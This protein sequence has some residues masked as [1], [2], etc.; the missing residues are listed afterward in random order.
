MAQ[1]GA[2]PPFLGTICY[3]A[4]DFALEVLFTR[5]A[6]S[7]FLRLS[8]PFPAIVEISIAHVCSVPGSVWGGSALREKVKKRNFYNL[9]CVLIALCGV[10]LRVSEVSQTH[11]GACVC[12][13]MERM[14]VNALMLAVSTK[15][16]F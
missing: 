9:T 5:L 2:V 4:L 12:G 10:I 11:F 14:R 16:I 7:A 8:P 6:C 1:R 3:L 13:L 15:N